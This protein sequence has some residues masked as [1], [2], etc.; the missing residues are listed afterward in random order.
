LTFFSATPRR[1]YRYKSQLFWDLFYD[2]ICDVF[3]GMKRLEARKLVS[4]FGP[5][6]AKRAEAKKAEE[7]A[8][9]EA[10]FRRRVQ[11]SL[12][13]QGGGGGQETDAGGED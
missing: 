8:A 11:V 13:T 4:D 2:L 9:A 1:V 7:A 6:F 10:D 5:L 12:E 3:A